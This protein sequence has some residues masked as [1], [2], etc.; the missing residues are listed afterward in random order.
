MGWDSLAKGSGVGVALTCFVCGC[1]LVI[2]Q[3]PERA[4]E[5][6]RDASATLD[7]TVRDASMGDANTLDASRDGG[8]QDASDSGPGLDAVVPMGCDVLAPAFNPADLVRED[9][10]FAD[11][12]SD[13]RNCSNVTLSNPS[14]FSDDSPIAQGSNFNGTIS[15]EVLFLQ[16]D[17]N[18][19]SELI[20]TFSEP[21]VEFAFSIE[22][23]SLGPEVDECME[24]LTDEDSRLAVNS[25]TISV[26][27]RILK[28]STLTSRGVVN[29]QAES[30][31]GFTWVKLRLIN[32]DDG[33]GGGIELHNF[34]V[35]YR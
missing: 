15:G 33:D 26:A 17:G 9:G 3:G 10:V 35:R 25:A 27:N 19:T 12:F 21:V 8:E 11:Q 6:T 24:I 16:A 4:A 7:G 23:L 30:D 29:V 31:A 5:Q 13:A 14:P 34:L 32:L 20:V 1:G 28:A 22:G 2:D 18:S